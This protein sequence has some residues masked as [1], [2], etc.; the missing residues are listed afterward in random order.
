[1]PSLEHPSGRIPVR[2][3]ICFVI[4]YSGQWPFWFPFFLESCK[5]NPDIIWILY[6]DCITP[7]D[8]PTNIRIVNTGYSSYCKNVSD[9]LGILF[10]PSSPYKLCDLKPALG[11]I[12]RADLKNYEFWTFGD[13]DLVYGDLRHH[14]TDDRLARHDIFSTHQQRVSDHCC[15]LR[16]TPLMR[17][18]FM[19]IKNW[20]QLLS[21]H[22][23]QWFDECAFS[24]MFIPHKKRHPALAR[25]AKPFNRWTRRIESIEAFTTPYA[26]IP[27]TDGTYDFPQEWR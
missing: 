12:H 16:N 23:H 9:S 6:S 14:F 22:Q 5:A 7:D 20:R 27:R 17:E 4:P 26:K 25:M 18:A 1:M 19:D 13:S 10:Q 2:P 15:L 8:L 3:K 11:Y 24:R 21:A